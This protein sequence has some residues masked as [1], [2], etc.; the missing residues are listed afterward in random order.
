MIPVMA[1]YDG[2]DVDDDHGHRMV[3]M[4]MVSVLRS[5]NINIIL[6]TIAAVAEQSPTY[7][8]MSYSGLGGPNWRRPSVDL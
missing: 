8:S 6:S 1:N 7:Y 5:N 4:I 2:R 3:V